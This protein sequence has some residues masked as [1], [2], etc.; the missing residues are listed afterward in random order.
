MLSAAWL[1]LA[2]GVVAAEV[3]PTAPGVRVE[4]VVVSP[5]D[6][7]RYRALVY[8]NGLQV[9][10]VE[11]PEASQAHWAVSVLA[12]SNQDPASLPG[13]NRLL[14]L[15]LFGDS[16]ASIDVQLEHTEYRARADAEPLTA[17]LAAFMARLTNPNTM[18]PQALKRGQHQLANDIR[19]GLGA[20]LADRR[21]DVFSALFNAQHPMARRQGVSASI[22][23]LPQV[24]QALS[25]TFTRY[26]TPARMRLVLQAN[27]PLAQQQRVLRTALSAVAKRPA[28]KASDEQYPPLFTPQTL[29][30]SLRIQAET[31]APQLQLLFPVPNPLALYAEKPLAEVSR[32]LA[33]GGPG[34]LLA[35]LKRLGWARAIDAGMG[36][37]SRH[38]GL[39]EVRVEL[40]ELGERAQEQVVALVFY[41]L[42]QIRTR[43]LRAWRHEELARTAALAFRYR[44]ANAQRDS[45]QLAHALHYYRPSDVLYGPYR[46]K[47]Y[48]ESLARRY[49]DFLRSDNVLISLTSGQ[50]LQQPSYSPVL[51]TPY[52]VSAASVKQP[53][54]KIAVRRQLNFPE[55][56][57]FIPTRL[58]AKE[59]SMLPSAHKPDAHSV[60]QLFNKPRFNAWFSRGPVASPAASVRMRLEIPAISASAAHAAAGQLLAELIRQALDESLFAARLAGADVTLSPH[61]L[62]VDIQVHGYNSQ[63][64]L[65]LTRIGQVIDELDIS[66]RAFNRAKATLTERLNRPPRTLK[67]YWQER[68]TELHYRPYWRRAE[69][70]AALT[71]IDAAQLQEFK[72]SRYR[73]RRLNVLFYGGLYR[74]EAQRLGALTEHTFLQDK[75]PAAPSVQYG[76]ASATPG[77]SL[78][79]PES[80]GTDRGVALYVQGQG[81]GASHS[82]QI[83]LAAQ[84]L[85]QA[86][87]AESELA[88]EL[89][90]V[91]PNTSPDND[92]EPA[93]SAEAT[94]GLDPAQVTVLTLHLAGRPALLVSYPDASLEPAA[95][96]AF[97]RQRLQR[98][99]PADAL[100]RA[101]E[102]VTQRL[103][104]G[105]G[106]SFRPASA[107]LWHSLLDELSAPQ[108]VATAL[109][110]LSASAT[111]RYRHEL[112]KRVDHSLMLVA[113]SAD[114]AAKPGV[115]AVSNY[116]ESLSKHLLSGPVLP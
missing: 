40:T 31:D 90:R 14:A 92:A 99:W 97:V 20:T 25:A 57:H 60:L 35:L 6:P 39:Y 63:L 21:Q 104:G 87:A 77:V 112:A 7:R 41:M 61:P 98:A 95:L 89:T 84:L 49:L 45:G 30:L 102:Q 38:D 79:L 103:S 36:V 11:D 106:H 94:H 110:R 78:A 54:I 59:P 4:E 115:P 105:Y 80:A 82:A 73:V 33:D 91:L 85:R 116:W 10:L 51:L 86:Q 62:G 55:R 83:M 74:Q 76:Q 2:A 81:A 75:A 23:P 68:L 111:E 22:A 64:G 71:A 34:S 43:G 46:F 27:M 48:N 66:E 100:K 9:L 88:P 70:A 56:N 32:L 13:L 109:S 107:Q 8:D 47:A 108:A 58:S 28:G 3:S 37:Q 52:R 18:T 69:R 12:G 113:S 67:A 24:T 42:E 16:A 93:P 53:D 17:A 101:R 50:P 26:Y 5:Q 114:T 44:D 65:M 1:T 29:P 96:R 72:H 15:V 19:A